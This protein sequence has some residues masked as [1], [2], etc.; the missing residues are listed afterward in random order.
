VAYERP[1]MFGE[2]NVVTTDTRV[3]DATSGVP[4]KPMVPTAHTSPATNPSR[5]MRRHIGQPL[6]SAQGD[7]R[8][9][10]KEQSVGHGQWR[11]GV[12]LRSTRA[13]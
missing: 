2:G 3:D 11:T 13:A 9:P 7:E 5:P 10:A 4:N 1:A 12:G 8:R 6:D